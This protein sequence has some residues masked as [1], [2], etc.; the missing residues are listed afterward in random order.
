LKVEIQKLIV[1]A[2]AIL[3]LALIVKN[4]FSDAMVLAVGLVG[5]IS[6]TTLSDRQSKMID[7]FTQE[8]V[9]DKL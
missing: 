4:Q 1:V 7:E 6:Q 3:A 8:M 9:D 2:V 5:F